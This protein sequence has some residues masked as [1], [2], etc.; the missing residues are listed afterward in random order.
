MRQPVALRVSSAWRRL[1]LESPSTRSAWASSR[2]MTVLSQAMRQVLPLAL[3]VSW[4]ATGAGRPA[5][6]TGMGTAAELAGRFGIDIRTPD[7][8]RGSLGIIEK[9]LE[10]YLA[11][12]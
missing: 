4:Q 6:G 5:A 12:L 7:F 3:S 9:R 1:T 8:W 10:R 11:L 2:P